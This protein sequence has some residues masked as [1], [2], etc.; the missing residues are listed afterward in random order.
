MICQ[1]WKQLGCALPV[2]GPYTRLNFG[3]RPA[4]ERNRLSLAVGKPRISPGIYNGHK[5]YHSVGVMPS[6]NTMQATQFNPHHNIQTTHSEINGCS[7]SHICCNIPHWHCLF[8]PMILCSN[9]K[10][11]WQWQR[12]KPIKHRQNYRSCYMNNEILSENTVCDKKS[13]HVN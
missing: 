9:K 7:T 10:N 13:K 2:P 8:T 11:T 1:R 4:N 12:R 6:V 3:L 5:L